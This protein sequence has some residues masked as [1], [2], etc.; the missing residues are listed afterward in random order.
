VPAPAS[1]ATAA[2]PERG[3]CARKSVGTHPQLMVVGVGNPI[4]VLR[5][6]RM[7]LGGVNPVSAIRAISTYRGASVRRAFKNIMCTVPT[8][9]SPARA[10]RYDFSRMNTHKDSPNKEAGGTAKKRLA[11]RTDIST[12]GRW[13]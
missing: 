13:C 1:G 12:V 4:A 10:V 2:A 9:R 11:I 5:V 6:A 8:P 3:A 7:G